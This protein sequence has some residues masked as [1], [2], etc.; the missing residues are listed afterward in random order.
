[1]DPVDDF[2]VEV[3]YSREPA[4][5]ELAAAAA[6]FFAARHVIG[7]SS[8]TI[9]G[10]IHR[11]V[12]GLCLDKNER[13]FIAPP[14]T[15]PIPLPDIGLLDRQLRELTGLSMVTE[16]ELYDDDDIDSV[17]DASAVAEAHTVIVVPRSRLR[18]AQTT[19]SGL[20]AMG[21]LLAGATDEKVSVIDDGEDIVILVP[22]AIPMPS[23]EF[24]PALICCVQWPD[25][26]R[27]INFSR[28]MKSGAEE[29]AVMTWTD[30][31]RRPFF[32]D[33]SLPTNPYA[34]VLRDE[35]W[36]C[37]NL[38]ALAQERSLSEES[39]AALASA[40]RDDD[41]ATGFDRAVDLL[42]LPIGVK[43]AISTGTWSDEGVTAITVEPTRHAVLKASFLLAV[44]GESSSADRNYSGAEWYAV[45]QR[46]LNNHPTAHLV[47]IALCI[48]LGITQITRWLLTGEAGWLAFRPV[49]AI[50]LV[51][52]VVPSQT[53]LFLAA[54]RYRH[55]FKEQVEAREDHTPLD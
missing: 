51:V 54:R 15:D 40:S 31:P 41:V 37:K 29:Y 13:V 53:L 30:A 34:S 10:G 14:G 55:A 5:P 17:L 36:G 19:E 49:T 47:Y 22:D 42:R 26:D 21:M 7:W 33:W 3:F 27:S 48:L 32:P 12:V 50:V 4:T 2:Y 23:S 11:L 35:L 9:L 52:L 25:G 45:P 28:E 39:I 18:S 44:G 16:D 38:E 46:W 43:Q 24:F 1:M 8:Y 20:R 6:E